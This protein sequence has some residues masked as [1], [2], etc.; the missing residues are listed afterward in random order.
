MMTR[1]INT[2]DAKQVG[3]ERGYD[4]GKHVGLGPTASFVGLLDDENGELTAKILWEELEEECHLEAMETEENA[5]QYSDFARFASL[6]NE[7]SETEADE[8]WN[9]YEC[10]VLKGIA[11][12]FDE[13]K[14]KF[15]N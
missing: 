4:A 10:G 5:R 7:H 3:I 13:A 15:K 11:I 8:L 2:E 9:A 6:I 14:A 12:A 1:R